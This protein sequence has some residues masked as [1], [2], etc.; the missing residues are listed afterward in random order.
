MKSFRDHLELSNSCSYDVDEVIGRAD[1]SGFQNF[2][3]PVLEYLA[4]INWTNFYY[5]YIYNTNFS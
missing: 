2:C 1:R 3:S 5:M 4:D